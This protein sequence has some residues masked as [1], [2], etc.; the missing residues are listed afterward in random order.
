MTKKRPTP[1]DDAA[2]AEG[3]TAKERGLS[4][5]SCPYFFDKL[6]VTQEQFERDYRA[7]M[8]GWTYGWIEANEEKR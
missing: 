6:G 8:N 3:R 7:K 4:Y 5:Q 1:F 2:Y